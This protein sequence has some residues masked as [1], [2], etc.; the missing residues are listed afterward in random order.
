MDDDKGDDEGD[1]KRDFAQKIG[2]WSRYV[3][4]GR[5]STYFG[6]HL[7]EAAYETLSNA[8][9]IL[10]TWLEHRSPQWGQRL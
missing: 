4:H 6:L 5:G 1:D 10:P 3:A 2:S 7:L 9:R 8:E